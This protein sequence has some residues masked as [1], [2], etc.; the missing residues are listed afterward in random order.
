M[1]V[2]PKV[3]IV[4]LHRPQMTAV[5]ITRNLTRVDS[6]TNQISPNK[7]N[8]MKIT[9]VIPTLGKGGA[10]DVIIT[11]ANSLAIDNDIKVV[12]L[13][14][15]A[16]DRYNVSRIDEKVAVSFLFDR[17]DYGST[18]GSI[19]TSLETVLS[20][21]AYYFKAKVYRSDI[22]HVNLTMGSLLGSIFQLLSL[23]LRH[24][25]TY[26]ETFHTNLHLLPLSRR[27]IFISAGI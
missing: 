3:F 10:E 2:C 15:V 24:K 17:E 4:T 27:L 23:V 11:L 14:N 6:Y 19:L 5:S 18:N 12:V 21:V 20:G 7:A 25:P 1:H 13:R 22:I 26:V 8:N 9:Y 16:E